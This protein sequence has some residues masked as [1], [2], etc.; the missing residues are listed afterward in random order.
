MY[1][2]SEQLL[3]LVINGFDVPI[4]CLTENS[5]NETSE[6]LDTTTTDNAGWKTSI[7]LNQEYNIDFT[8]IEVLSDI[9][10]PTLYSYDLLKQLKRNR[11]RVTWKKAINV[12]EVVE[13]GYGYITDLGETSPAGEFITFNGTIKGY[14]VPVSTTNYTMQDGNNFIFND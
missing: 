5:F 12:D 14:G 6:M 8:G 7:P 9:E 4:G 10:T 3:Y 1:K 11:E 2:G 13:T